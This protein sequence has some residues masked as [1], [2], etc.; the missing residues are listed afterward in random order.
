M[1]RDQEVGGSNPLAP[2]ICFHKVRSVNS[3]K[4]P[5]YR[6]VLVVGQTAQYCIVKT[7]MGSIWG[8]LGFFKIVRGRNA[9][10]IDNY[11]SVAQ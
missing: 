1:V 7:S 6:A 3:T 11:L 4:P 2:T 8:F 9:C 10:G 5:E